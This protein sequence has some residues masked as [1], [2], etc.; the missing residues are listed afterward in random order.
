MQGY[1]EARLA[2]SLVCLVHYVSGDLRER[3]RI[4]MGDQHGI[5]GSHLREGRTARPTAYGIV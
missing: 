1:A 4:V 5:T 2:G 3:H